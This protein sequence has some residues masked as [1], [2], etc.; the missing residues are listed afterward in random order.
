MLTRSNTSHS[1]TKMFV[2]HVEP[3]SVKQAMAH[4]NWIQSIQLENNALMENQ[5]CTLITL[6]PLRRPMGYMWMFKVKE[7]HDGTMN[8]YKSRLVAK[9]Y[10][11]QHGFNFNETFSFMVKPTTIR[12]VLTLTLTNH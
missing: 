8:K 3:T 10:H 4:P 12:V 2:Y 6:P 1:K 9:G 7:N 11:R 5:T